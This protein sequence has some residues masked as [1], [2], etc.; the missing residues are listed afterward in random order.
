VPALILSCPFP[1]FPSLPTRAPAE[2][3]PPLFFGCRVLFPPLSKNVI[4]RCSFFVKTRV[5]EE[6]SFYSIPVSLPF[7]SFLLGRGDGQGDR[8]SGPR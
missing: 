1:S 5:V 6:K 2:Y 4:R 8:S 3:A 7:F